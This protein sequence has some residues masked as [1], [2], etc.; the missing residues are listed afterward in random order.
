VRGVHLVRPS[1][2]EKGRARLTVRARSVSKVG[3]A[4]YSDQT[5]GSPLMKEGVTLRRV[6]SESSPFDA[7]E[8]SDLDVNIECCCPPRLNSSDRCAFIAST[9]SFGRSG[10]TGDTAALRTGDR[11]L[12]SHSGDLE[13]RG[14]TAC[15]AIMP[16]PVSSSKTESCE[17]CTGK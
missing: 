6:C 16:V 14:R 5:E 1:L 8:S 2:L 3:I 13:R 4:E 17:E 10:R 12:L 15:C 11:C 9:S 7:A